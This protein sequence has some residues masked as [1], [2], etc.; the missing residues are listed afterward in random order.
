MHMENV[1][2]H[3]NEVERKYHRCG[4]IQIKTVT[5]KVILRKATVLKVCVS[6]LSD[7][8]DS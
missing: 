4:Y 5:L 7:Q 6:K 1:H 8:E 3:K 2:Y